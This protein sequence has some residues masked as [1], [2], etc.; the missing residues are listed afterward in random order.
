M[1]TM[2]ANQKVLDL[3]KQKCSQAA[4][5]MAHVATAGAEAV[6]TFTFEIGSLQDFSSKD[7]RADTEHSA[8]FKQ[9]A[10]IKG[11]VVYFFEIIS[12]ISPAEVLSAA[13]SYKGGSRI[14]PAFRSN[15]DNT[16]QV[17]YVGKVKSNFQARVVQH[18][19]F[20]R[21]AATQGLQMYH[22]TRGLDLKVE[23]TVLEFKVD[24]AD[25]LPLIEKAIA[26]QLKPLLGKHQ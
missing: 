13:E 12:S 5:P 25:L 4:A 18:L 16:S 2:P 9:L 6:H 26:T 11:P 20:S 1:L 17:L 24:M 22:W 8:V 7:I 14:M 3:V 21:T 19:G 15:P 10:A 23:L